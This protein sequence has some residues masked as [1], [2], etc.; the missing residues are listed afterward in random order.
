MA[1]CFLA[2]HH[3][4]RPAGITL[5]GLFFAFLAHPRPFPR[6]PCRVMALPWPCLAIPGALLGFLAFLPPLRSRYVPE[7]CF[8]MIH[9][10]ACLL[11]LAMRSAGSPCLPVAMNASNE[12]K[13][14]RLRHAIMHDLSIAYPIL[15][16]HGDL[17]RTP[18][19]YVAID[20]EAVLR[21]A[22]C[23]IE[24]LKAD[25]PASEA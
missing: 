15:A 9:G 7:S 23:L 17:E 20:P 12:F 25:M 6:L 11:G 10:R 14:A 8:G 5:A 21:R 3:L 1:H 22:R 13:I 4:P 2:F 18:N 19:G 24:V 16:E